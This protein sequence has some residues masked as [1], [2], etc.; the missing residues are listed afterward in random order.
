MKNKIKNSCNQPNVVARTCNSQH[1]GR[2]R[3]EDHHLSPGVWDQPRQH[4]EI[5][6]LECFKLAGVKKKKKG[7]KKNLGIQLASKGPIQELQNTAQRNQKHKQLK[8][9]PC[10]WIQRINIIKMAILLKAI[11]RDSMLFLVNYHWH[12]S[13]N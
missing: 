11:Y 12:S 6:S 1:F 9:I 10:S 13:K 4:G 2:L 8:D 7:R 3:Q 5:P